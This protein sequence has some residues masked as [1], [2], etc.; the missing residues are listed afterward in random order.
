MQQSFSQ[1]VVSTFLS[2]ANIDRL[3]HEIARMTRDYSLIDSH[4]NILERAISYSREIR[5]DLRWSNPLPGVTAGDLVDN[6]N[7]EFV[8]AYAPK[9]LQSVP[10][11]YEITDGYTAMRS[12]YAG[13]SA[14][15]LLDKWWLGGSKPIVMRDDRHGDRKE[16]MGDADYLMQHC[17]TPAVKLHQNVENRR[18][19]Q[20]VPRTQK[21]VVAKYADIAANKWIR[22]HN[23]DPR[24]TEGFS[25]SFTYS[26]QG[27]YVVNGAEP[28]APAFDYLSSVFVSPTVKQWDSLTEPYQRIP[29]GTNS[30]IADERI[31][32]R[33]LTRKTMSSWDNG[34]RR[35]EHRLYKRRYDS[36]AADAGLEG[37]ELEA[38]PR[39]FDMSTL[40]RQVSAKQANRWKC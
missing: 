23:L 29:L 33:N 4:H 14:D 27:G 24:D 12:S 38:P 19:M 8:S 3:V 32:S 1:R 26:G 28:E 17:S 25:G 22:D 2:P 31:A 10:Q 35:M 21:D 37:A 40:Q 7:R 39:R 6:Y 11:H 18:S 15:D 30:E 9:E 34:I 16:S 36:A 20:V 5:E 13:M